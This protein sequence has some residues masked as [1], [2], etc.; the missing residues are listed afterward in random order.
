MRSAEQMQSAC[1]T[2]TGAGNRVGIVSAA[3]ESFGTGFTG[4]TGTGAY[5]SITPCRFR[6]AT[7]TLTSRGGGTDA[8]RARIT[9]QPDHDN[10]DQTRRY[11][12]IGR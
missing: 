3:V 12:A 2:I 4:K 7:L 8:Y 10:R 5:T 1:R 6:P 11:L 9:A